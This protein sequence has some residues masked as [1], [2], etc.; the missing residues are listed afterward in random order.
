LC[1]GA[2]VLVCVTVNLG[3][4]LDDG[5]GLDRLAAVCMVDGSESLECGDDDLWSFGREQRDEFINDGVGY[6]KLDV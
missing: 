2:N 1:F 3:Q 6:V 4:Q 5:L